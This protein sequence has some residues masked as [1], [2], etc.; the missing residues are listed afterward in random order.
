VIRSLPESLDRLLRSVPQLQS[1]YLVGGAVRDALF[2]LPGGKDF[3][4]EVFGIDYDTL[5]AVL[6]PFGRVDLVGRSF[7][8]VK[9]SIDGAVHDFSIPRRDSKTAPG[10]RGFEV[11]FDAAI[12]PREASARRDFTINTL[13]LEPRTGELLD[14]HGGVR[15]LES[16]V[17]RHT[18]EAFVEDPLRV[19]RGMQFAGRFDLTAAPE[20][21]ELCRRIRGSYAELAQERVR[22]EWFKWAERSARP[23]A[24]LRFLEETGWIEHFPEITAIRGVPQDPEWHPEGDVL[25]HTSHALDALVGLDEWR[26]A[27][28]VTRIVLTLAVLAHDFGK[29]VCTRTLEREGRQRIVS[30]GHES[31]SARIAES[32]LNRINAPRQFI[33]RIVP[34]VANHMAAFQECTERAVRRLARRIQPETIEHLGT[35]I[36]A[37]ASGRPPLPPGVPASVIQLVSVARGLAVSDAAPRPILLGRHLLS[38]GF[39]P[40]PEVGH[41]TELALEAQLDGR[42]RDLAGAHSWLADQVEFPEHFRHR[43]ELRGRGVGGADFNAAE[44]PSRPD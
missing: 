25:T 13:M 15:D 40:G 24:G 44:A 6:Q 36:T 9:L 14:F 42:F 31:E 4:L 11:R 8:V 21:L 22:E 12:T 23:S 29:A 35:V 19:L 39:A 28:S 20:T 34:L 2:G 41:W 1:T 5:S 7:G 33:S 30:P 18:S 37:D 26:G 16:R 32:F 17:L 27:D 43:A 3:D 38:L 10:H